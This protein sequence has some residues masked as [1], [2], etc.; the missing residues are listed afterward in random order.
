MVYGDQNLLSV[1]LDNLL[2]NAWKYTSKTGAAEIDFGQIHSQ[3]GHHVFFVKDNGAGFDM[4]YVEKIF[5]AFQRL[6]TPDEFPGTGIGLATVQRIIDRHR[7]KIW[8]ESE[9]GKGTTIFFTLDTNESTE[10][11]G[12]K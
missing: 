11:C 12:G 5:A 9:V 3:N 10:D 2:G 1:A 6:H 8:A 7:G 4:K